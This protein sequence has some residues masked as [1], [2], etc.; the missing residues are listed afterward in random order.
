MPTFQSDSVEKQRVVIGHIRKAGQAVLGVN[1][2]FPGQV[3]G[4]AVEFLV[5]EVAPASNG[6]TEREGGRGQVGPFRKAQAVPPGEQVQ[7]NGAA[8]DAAG[9]PQSAFPQV[10]EVEGVRQVIPGVYPLRH[11]RGRGG[12]DVPQARADDG[13]NH[14]PDEQIPHQVGVVSAPGRPPR[15]QRAARQR[16]GH[17]D[18][19]VVIQDELGGQTGK[20][21]CLLNS[22]RMFPAP[23][24]AAMC[25]RAHPGNALQ[26]GDVRQHGHNP[27]GDD[28]L[29]QHQ[30]RASTR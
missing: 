4:G 23:L 26:C 29:I 1:V 14:Q 28:R 25:L 18:E 24:A 15:R 13:A 8:E 20:S 27:H 9:Q 11:Q 30:Q 2:Q 22:K 17:D 16:A 5:E 10:D 21:E 7:G 19:T 12:E 3:G 6:L